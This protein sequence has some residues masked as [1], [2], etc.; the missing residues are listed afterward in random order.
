M[1]NEE[2]E[3]SREKYQKVKETIL[4]PETEGE[5]IH[6]STT[7]I[8]AEQAFGEYAIQ[9]NCDEE[10]ARTF[11]EENVEIRFCPV[12]DI[13]LPNSSKLET[14][15]SK[16]IS[17][18]QGSKALGAI[19]PTKDGGCIFCLDV[20]GIAKSLPKLKTPGFRVV[21][22][23]RMT[24]EQK[25][26]AFK[27]AVESLSEHEFFHLIQY[28]RDAEAFKK[29]SSKVKLSHKI[30][31]TW[32]GAAGVMT[33]TTSAEMG[34]PVVTSTGLATIGAVV[35]FGREQR[36]IEKDAYDAQKEALQ[37]HLKPPFNF[38][39][40]STPHRSNPESLKL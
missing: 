39:H 13:P 26:A 17:R 2:L 19:V 7:P 23:S 27:Q 15:A 14:T 34:F 10:E 36:K 31:L 4:L 5:Y 6:I 32:V 33:G 28:M 8:R 1:V 22:Y 35:Y 40:E 30:F 18:A 11:F 37:L 21:K 29:A 12:D 9:F 20:E 3:V 25:I 16:L 38:D 24:V